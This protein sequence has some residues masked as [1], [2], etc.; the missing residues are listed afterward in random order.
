[1]FVSEVI[2]NK[3]VQTVGVGAVSAMV[4]GVGGYFFA[5]WRMKLAI[6]D[7]FKRNE[8]MTLF[9]AA[10]N[11][12][13]EAVVDR[14]VMT[15]KLRDIREQADDADVE[16]EARRVARLEAR[17]H[18]ELLEPY[19][20][21]A[22][23][24]ETAVDEADRA[25]IVGDDEYHGEIIGGQVEEAEVVED[26]V[27]KN[28]FVREHDVWDFDKE[29][30]NRGRGKPY[31][32][33]EEEFIANEREDDGY[34]Q[35]TLTYYVKDNVMADPLDKGMCGALL[36]GHGANSDSIVY[37]RNEE[38]RHEWEILK[39]EG[40]FVEETQGLREIDEAEE[41]LQHSVGKF[42]RDD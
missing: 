4:G 28:V 24:I 1:V 33:H 34:K 29:V 35:E 6:L 32:I 20:A 42:R 14:S 7:A 15:K 5:K 10:L 40:S 30:A 26:R 12:R 3:T 41:S 2:K 36:W 13:P 16:R 27:R 9:D 39:H 11:V 18:Q 31:V 17:R 19:M 22:E 8:E 21:V 23:A 38:I 25:I 37:I